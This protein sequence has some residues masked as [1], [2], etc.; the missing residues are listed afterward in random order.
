MSNNPGNQFVS[1]PA[2]SDNCNTGYIRG[3]FFTIWV[4][5]RPSALGELNNWAFSVDF[6]EFL[7]DEGVEQIFIAEIETALVINT[8]LLNFQKNGVPH[9]HPEHGPELSLPKTFWEFELKNDT[10]E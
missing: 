2:Y 5:Q 1:G 3:I 6:L 8:T 7:D 10:G 9:L 4:Y